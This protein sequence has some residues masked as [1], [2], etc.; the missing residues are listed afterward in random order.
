MR[1]VRDCITY[2]AENMRRYNPIN[3][4][5]Y[6]ISEAGASPLQEAAFTLANVIVYVEEVVKTGMHVDEFA[7]R[8]A[9]F[10]VCQADF[11]EEI[12][13]FRAA[14]R[15]LAQDHEGA[16]R[17]E[18]SG[19]HAVAFPLPDGR[20]VTDKAAIHG[21]HRAHPDAGAGGRAWRLPVLAHQRLRRGI[22]DPYR[23]C[24]A[25]GLAHAAGHRRRDQRDA[26]WSIRSVAPTTS[27][28]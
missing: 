3:I 27:K 18:E 22:R 19:I 9:F 28:A 6:H 21:Q 12:A 7:P 26:E 24:D 23:R 13:K 16:V 4:S 14:R 15:C 17:R 11:F 8:L 2:C 20:R 1:I 10:F 25:H 5:G